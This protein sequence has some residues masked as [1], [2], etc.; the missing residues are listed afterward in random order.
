MN[1]SLL[2][3][4]LADDEKL[5]LAGLQKLLPWEELGFSICGTAENGQKALLMIAEKQPDIV[6]TDLK[7]PS[8]DGISLANQLAK[9]SPETIIIVITGYDE[10]QYAKAALH[11]GV[12]EFLLKPVSPKELKNALIR[13]TD[14]IQNRKFSYPFKLEESLITAVMQGKFAD[15]LHFLDTIFEDFYKQRIPSDTA[16]KICEK[17]LTE[18]NICYSKFIG[19]DDYNMEVRIE[20]AS[21]LPEMKMLLSNYLNH[22]LMQE[23]SSSDILVEQIILYLKSHYQENITLKVLENEFFFNSSY[24]SRI[25]KQKTGENYNDYLLKIRIEH[26]KELLTMTNRPIIQ[27]SEM[28]GFGNSKYFTRI[29]KSVTGL[30]PVNYRTMYRKQQ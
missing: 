22:I 26:A 2:T 23:T 4:L 9:D 8:V 17:L 25:F 20:P 3:V 16:R 11:A 6:I 29:F 21:T 5:I 18:L 24:I 13:A 14:K 12:F 15:A 30:T 7:M 10:F 1:T 19:C 28:S 27:I